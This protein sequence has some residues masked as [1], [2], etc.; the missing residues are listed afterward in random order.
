MVA[1]TLLCQMVSSSS[2]SGSGSG[3]GAGGGGSGGVQSTIAAAATLSTGLGLGLGLAQRLQL[4]ALLLDMQYSQPL[5]AY[6]AA[7]LCR[8]LALLAKFGWYEL[9]PAAPPAAA[10]AAQGNSGG[11]L[12][13]SVLHDVEPFV[14]SGSRLQLATACQL[15]NQV[16]QQ[17]D[18]PSPVHGVAKHRQVGGCM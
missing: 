10:A 9:A 3:S 6:V 8:L 2:G 11:Y 7:E 5:Q 4:K 17:M 1:A 13:R 16:V 12:F 14:A 18:R 15:L